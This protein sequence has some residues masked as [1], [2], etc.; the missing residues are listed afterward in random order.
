MDEMLACSRAAARDADAASSRTAVGTAPAGVT[1]SAP[2]CS[3]AAAGAEASPGAGLLREAAP[4][5]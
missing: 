2:T 3:R 1:G 5:A 4:D